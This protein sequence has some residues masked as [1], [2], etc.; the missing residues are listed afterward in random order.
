MKKIFAVLMGL[1]LTLS[2]TALTLSQTQNKPDAQDKVVISSGEVLL[3]IVVR[4]KRNRLV[5]DLTP[6]DFEVYEDGVLQKVD[7]FRLIT[8]ESEATNKSEDKKANPPSNTSAANT[9][10]TLENSY[11]TVALVFDNLKTESRPF[12]CRAAQAYTNENI[13]TKDYVGVFSVG[14]TLSPVQV[15]TRDPN[16]IKKA[17][18]QVQSISFANPS[19]PG[20]GLNQRP[21]F[22]QLQAYQQ[23][24]SSGPG[25][26][27]SG[28]L[29]INIKMAQ[30]TS[31][32]LESFA[33]MESQQRGQSVVNSLMAII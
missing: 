21:N 26:A 29:A 11:S 19:A 24:A 23:A 8:R 31:S 3:D 30:M 16:Q 4:D 7:S 5:K 25:G 10:I 6:A 20:A 13:T 12:A 1:M 9:P 17:I 2:N 14:L 32:I 28:Q 27:A 22:E 33:H 18:D 15:F